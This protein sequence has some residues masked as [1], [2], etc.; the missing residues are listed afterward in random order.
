VNKVLWSGGGGGG[1]ATLYTWWGSVDTNWSNRFNWNPSPGCVPPGAADSA[2]IVTTATV[3]PILTANVAISTLTINS[4]TATVTLNGFNLTVASF[5]NAG[6][7]LFKGT[8][9]FPRAQEPGGFERH[10]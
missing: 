8:E 6:N 2:L 10:L 5:T 1:T 3:M 4:G 7:F 9:Q